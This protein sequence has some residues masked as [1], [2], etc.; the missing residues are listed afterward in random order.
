MAEKQLS[1]ISDVLALEEE[2]AKQAGIGFMGRALIQATLPHREQRGNE[3]TRK[4]GAFT[5]TILAPSHIGLPYGSIPRLLLS[6]V[7]TEAVRTRN[8]VLSLGP[9]LSAFMGELGLRRAGGPRGDITRLKDQTLRLFNSDFIFNYSGKNNDKGGKHAIAEKWSLWWEGGNPDQTP[10]WQSWVKL[11]PSFFEEVTERPVPVDMAALK[12]LKRSPLAL[13][14]Y[15]WLTY[16]MSY[17]SKPSVIPWPL[18][19]AQFGGDYAEGSQGQ[20]NFKKF[21]IKQL[22]NVLKV[23]DT[24]RVSTLPNGLLLK[25]SPPHVA[26]LAV[27]EVRAARSG[28]LPLPCAPPSASRS[29]DVVLK[30]ETFDKAKRLAPGMDVY[31]LEDE[32]REWMRK[33]G[34]TPARPDAAFLGFCKRKQA[35]HFPAI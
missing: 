4:N 17:L 10:L 30:T 25:P 31:F 22:K 7:T 5:L 34:K 15:F 9:S 35:E 1:L 33:T 8:H 21:F 3:F 18:L 29:C 16:R 6:W 32:W 26:K 23:Y 24:A 2:E 11:S 13:D 19:Q 20:R 14:A 27:P 28:Q 12:A